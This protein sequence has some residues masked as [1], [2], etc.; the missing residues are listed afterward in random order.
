VR[1]PPPPSLNLGPPNISETTKA[2]KLKFK[3]QLDMP[4][5]SFWV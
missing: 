4:K 3:E 1:C 2:R 5:Y